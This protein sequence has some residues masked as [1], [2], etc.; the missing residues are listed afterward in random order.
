VRC[1]ALHVSLKT[2]T[3]GKPRLKT[4]AWCWRKSSQRV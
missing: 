1:D 3:E 2:K 4:P